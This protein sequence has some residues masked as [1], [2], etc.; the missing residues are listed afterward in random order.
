MFG[1]SVQCVQNERG[2][3]KKCGDLAK[4]FELSDIPAERVTTLEG[5]F[6]RR[7]WP[8][9]LLHRLM[10][11]LPCRSLIHEPD[12]PELTIAPPVLGL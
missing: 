10:Q 6:L 1:Y 5:P 12:G 11:I 9:V 3:C 7:P 8:V 2:W 4:H